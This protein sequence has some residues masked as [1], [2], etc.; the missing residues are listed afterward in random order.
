MTTDAKMP[1]S[2]PTIPNSLY[3]LFR[4]DPP[5]PR[6]VVVA[7][8][9]IAGAGKSTLAK[10]IAVNHFYFTRVSI[11]AIVA[12]KHG[13]W[14]ND[15]LPDKY[16][17]YLDEAEEE[18]IERLRKLLSERKDVVL[19]RSFW[20]K[21][22]RES[23]RKIVEDEGGRWALVYLKAERDVLWRRIKKRQAGARDADSAFWITEQ[24]FDR[25]VKG[26]EAPDGEGEL[27]VEVN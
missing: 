27:V 8:C 9:G 11:D 16:E 24:V 6:P 22:D 17:E 26:F 25:Y 5:D 10:L 20:C 1:K 18:S 15:Y 4:R 19:D 14:G 2:R 21:A 7:M 3:P 12:E 23:V 13:L